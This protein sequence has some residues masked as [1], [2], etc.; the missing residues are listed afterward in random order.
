MAGST[1]QLRFEYTQDEFGIC[2]DVRPG[3]TCGVSFD[4]LVVN[5]VRSVV[6]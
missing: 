1:V 2:S 3:H 4:N 5:S 6:P